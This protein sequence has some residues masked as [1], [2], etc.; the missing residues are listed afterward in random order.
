ML[1]KDNWE[2]LLPCDTQGYRPSM[3]TVDA[4][5]LLDWAED[6]EYFA[7][8]SGDNAIDVAAS[9][10][11]YVG[12]HYNPYPYIVWPPDGHMYGCVN[13]CC[14]ICVP[15]PRTGEYSKYRDEYLKILAHDPRNHLTGNTDSVL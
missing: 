6:L 9:I 12:R 5:A 10:R 14:G 13:H 4:Y 7:E 3:R 1:G 11:A 8:W 15:D 2:R